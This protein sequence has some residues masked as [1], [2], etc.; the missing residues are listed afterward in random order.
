MEPWGG[1]P[2]PEQVAAAWQ[3]SV[4]AQERADREF[5]LAERYED[6]AEYSGD[7]THLRMGLLHRSTATRHQVAAELLAGHARRV[8][9]SR[10]SGGPPPPFM[11]G[12]AEACG[13]GSVA[14]TLVDAQQNQVA[15]ASSDRSA[16]DAQDL[17][18]VLGEG[19]ARDSVLARSPVVATGTA[20]ASR[21]PGYGPAFEALG[22]GQ[23]V[24]VPLKSAEA[25]IGALAVFSASS[26]AAPTPIVSQ[27]AD[28]LTRSVF[29][30]KDAVPGLFGD[31]DYRAEVHQAAG[32]VAVQLGCRVA[33][34]LEL[35]KARSFADGRPIG[36]IARDIVDGH[37]KLG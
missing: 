22:F 17:E 26:A 37:L 14:V 16:R 2:S 3:R 35:V 30:G 1:L 11:T 10:R 29:L 36:D 19:P 28:A 20:L 5:R 4:R 18:Y 33:D 13:V 25:C 23:V 6:L 9:D 8:A 31:I 32:M 34:A 7:V 12:V 24:A 15:T 21:W 27:V